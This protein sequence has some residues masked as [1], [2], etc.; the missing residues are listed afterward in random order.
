M[1]DTEVHLLGELREAMNDMPNNPEGI[2][3]WLLSHYQLAKIGTGEAATFHQAMVHGNGNVAVQVGKNGIPVSQ[4]LPEPQSPVATINKFLARAN[5]K[6]K[7]KSEIEA[8]MAASSGGGG[9]GNAA[10]IAAWNAPDADGGDGGG[11][12]MDAQV[13]VYA[14][15]LAGG[16]GGSGGGGGG[17]DDAAHNAIVNAFAGMGNGGGQAPSG[18]D[19]LAK[20]RTMNRQQINQEMRQTGGVGKIHRAG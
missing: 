2:A 19:M 6:P 9:G 15:A 7:S 5:V 16:G 20:I 11:E 17:D 1:S 10:L 3:G 18:A 8:A 4:R 12:P 14:N 13:Q